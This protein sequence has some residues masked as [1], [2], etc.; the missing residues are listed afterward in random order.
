MQG[1]FLGIYGGSLVDSQ[2][3]AFQKNQKK[4]KKEIEEKMEGATSEAAR[5]EKEPSLLSDIMA[6]VILEAPIV[7]VV[8]VFGLIIGHLEGWSIIERYGRRAIFSLENANL[9]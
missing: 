4:L 1:I 9:F 8:V 7:L 2:E 3:K 5:E 6:V